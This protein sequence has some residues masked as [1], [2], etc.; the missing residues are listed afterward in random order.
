MV[1]TVLLAVFA[2]LTTGLVA[3]DVTTVPEPKLI[4]VTLDSDVPAF[5]LTIA[6]HAERTRRDAAARI[7]EDMTDPAALYLIDF[8]GVGTTFSKPRGRITDAAGESRRG[9]ELRPLRRDY[10]REVDAAIVDIVQRVRED[11]PGARLTV[12]RLSDDPTGDFNGL[13]ANVDFVRA[14]KDTADDRGTNRVTKKRSKKSRTITAFGRSAGG[15]EEAVARHLA[16]G[17]PVLSESAGAWRIESQG[18]LPADFLDPGPARRMAWEAM[19]EVVITLPSRQDEPWASQHGPQTRASLDVW[20]AEYSRQENPIVGIMLTYRG[21]ADAQPETNPRGWRRRYADLPDKGWT[22]LDPILEDL[23]SLGYREVWFWG[24]P[25][26]HNIVDGR[27]SLVMPWYNTDGHTEIMRQTWPEFVRRWK[28]RGFR[29]GY[30]LGGV[31]I[32]NHGTT[33]QPNHQYITKRDIDYVVDTVAAIRDEGFEAVGLDAFVWIL[34]QRDMPDWANWR[35]T[36]HTGRREPGIARELLKSLRDDPR[37]RGMRI[38]TENRAPH[39]ELLSMAPTFQLMSSAAS[40][41]G[42]RPTVATLQPPIIEDLVNP[43]HEIIMMLSTSGWT[44]AEFDDAMAKIYGYG[45]RPA[46]AI[47]VLYQI[48]MLERGGRDI[49]D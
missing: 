9:R 32:P 20:P 4:R 27:S 29:F 33:E 22:V 42:N 17:R 49:D 39:G 2:L 18:P 19:D 21:I 10:Q 24:W 14:V 12:I 7:V 3:A 15:A 30:W 11:R 25:G 16:A 6:D 1:R 34:A 40:P 41:R 37:L 28:A 31:A 5:D 44:R 47:E 48:G 43:G 8:E 45:Y 23:E 26:E 38:V 35:M 13:L 36:N 46:V